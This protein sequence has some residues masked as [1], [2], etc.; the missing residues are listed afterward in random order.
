MQYEKC[1]TGTVFKYVSGTL[2]VSSGYG[3][4]N[5]SFKVICNTGCIHIAL[6]SRQEK[7][8]ANP[9]LRIQII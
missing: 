4:G 8:S 1:N 9:M 6:L 5:G 3:S 2:D 7:V